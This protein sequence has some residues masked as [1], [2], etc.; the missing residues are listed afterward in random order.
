MMPL[1]SQVGRDGDLL[2]QQAVLLA[3]GDRKPDRLEKGIRRQIELRPLGENVGR[4]ILHAVIK[5]GDGDV[6]V[7]IKN[8]AENTGQHPD[9]I[10]RGAA[11]DAGMQIA[12]GG[13]DLHFVVDQPA[14]RGG[15]RRRIG[16]PHAGVADQREVRLEVGLVLF[17]K[18]NEIL[19]SDFLFALD[20]DGDVE[21]QRARDRFP[22]PAGFDEGHQLALVVLG[23]ARD[24]DL[25]SVGMGGDFRLEWRTMPEIER[26]DRLHVVMAVEQHVRPGAVAFA[27][28]FALGD[29][30]GMTGRRPDLGR[31]AERRDIAGKMIGSRLAIS[32]KGRIGRD[33][34]DPQQG[35]QPLEGMIEIGI[36]AVEDR[37][38]LRRVGHFAIFPGASGLLLGISGL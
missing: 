8:A 13:L 22:G 34:L 37:L 25:S 24:D 36:D 16:V 1:M 28:A 31:K 5:A 17:K 3:G 26:V 27:V 7:F 23:A 10:L 12:V 21:R 29:D 30:G 18:R 11:E 35:K 33:R 9:R 4:K 6:A 15:D 19:R 32:G 14:Q 20:D 2:D 38:Q